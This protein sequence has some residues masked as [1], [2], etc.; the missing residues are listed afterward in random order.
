[1]FQAFDLDLGQS[2]NWYKRILGTWKQKEKLE[3][4]EMDDES[5]IIVFGES[6]A[7]GRSIAS[8]NKN[9]DSTCTSVST[10]ME[11]TCQKEIESIH[12]VGRSTRSLS[13]SQTIDFTQYCKNQLRGGPRQLGRVKWESDDI[14]DSSKEK[15]DDCAKLDNRQNA[16]CVHL[17]DLN[18]RSIRRLAQSQSKEWKSCM[19]VKKHKRSLIVRK[20]LEDEERE[21][22]F[23]DDSSVSLTP[24]V[25][26]MTLE[27]VSEGE[28]VSMIKDSAKTTIQ[29]NTM[30]RSDRMEEDMSKKENC[31]L[32][33]QRK[34]EK[35]DENSTYDN[36]K[37]GRRAGVQST[38]NCA[39]LIGKVK[40]SKVRS[41]MELSDLGSDLT[42]ETR[43]KM[44]MKN[45]V[46]D[47]QVTGLPDGIECEK[48]FSKNV[49]KR[50][51]PTTYPTGHPKKYSES[52]NKHNVE[53]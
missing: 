22:G 32:S 40:I 2:K 31:V 35:Y 51:D 5:D 13:S 19:K 14:E 43:E 26:M 20:L 10:T 37:I 23:K 28:M 39:H 42:S 21:L 12:D 52:L 3:H 30:L 7:C 48:F 9:D 46:Q 16:S 47:L 4:H 17:E 33:C 41:L 11:P 53:S 24:S 36:R 1:M 27:E 6:S 44:S 34:N 8:T 50:V 38:G 45:D 49:H 29:M 18:G 15:W 25:S